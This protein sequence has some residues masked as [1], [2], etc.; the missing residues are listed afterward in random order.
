MLID[1]LYGMASPKQS[2]GHAQKLAAAKALL[3]DKYL[4]AKPVKKL[5]TPNK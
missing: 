1:S 5:D 4:L 3:G 2:K